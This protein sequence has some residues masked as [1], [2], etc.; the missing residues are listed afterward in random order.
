MSR[1]LIP[2]KISNIKTMDNRGQEISPGILLIAHFHPRIF[3]ASL[4]FVSMNVQR[5]KCYLLSHCSFLL[6]EQVFYAELLYALRNHLWN[7]EK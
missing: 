3:L 6:I 5:V 1:L 7:K 2:T 4:T